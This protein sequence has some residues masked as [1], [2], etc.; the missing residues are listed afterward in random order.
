M[1]VAAPPRARRAAAA[2]AARVPSSPAYVDLTSLHFQPRAAAPRQRA[3]RAVSP[4]ADEHL[5]SC[6]GASRSPAW[7]VGL[8]Q[9]SDLFWS[10]FVVALASYDSAEPRCE[11]LHHGGRAQSPREPL[12]RHAHEAAGRGW[13]RRQV[14]SQRHTPL[15]TFRCFAFVNFVSPAHAAGFAQAFRGF[16]EWEVP[17]DREAEVAWSS[18]Q[19]LEQQVERYRNSPVMHDSFPDEWKPLLLRGG[20]WQRFPPPTRRLRHVRLRQRRSVDLRH[21]KN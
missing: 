16:S 8:S 14:R 10:D 19:G 11:G 21:L 1:L 18:L 12:A 6:C 20:A 5:D 4:R 3:P 13:L 7:S 15:P 17:W 2:G 9:A